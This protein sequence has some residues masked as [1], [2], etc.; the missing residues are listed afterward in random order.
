MTKPPSQTLRFA[1]LAGRRPTEFALEPT[2]KD[3]E[4]IA[5][6]LEV[7]AI[8]KLTFKGKVTP[9]D[10][11]DW[12]LTAELGATVVQPCV[13]T[14]DP[15][16]TRL[17]ENIVRRYLAELPEIAGPEIEMPEDDSAEAL[18][19]T[20][21]LYEVLIESLALALPAFPRKDGAES[22]EII[23]AA[24]GVRPM[25]DDDAKPFAALG[26]LRDALSDKDDGKS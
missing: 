23:A 22:G 15:V 25:T 6:E 26:A 17:D 24:P 8:K 5:K 7:T 9:L 11:R 19:A 14:L 16:T 1:D 10:A 18:P 2:A 4:T 12:E 3:K 21:D 20:I 13:V